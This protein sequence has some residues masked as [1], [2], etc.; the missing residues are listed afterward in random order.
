MLIPLRAAGTHNPTKRPI[1]GVFMFTHK[2]ARRKRCVAHM[3][4][5]RFA[6]TDIVARR[7]CPKCASEKALACAPIVLASCE[8]MTSELL[9]CLDILEMVEAFVASPEKPVWS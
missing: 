1:K 5:T 9:S 8:P 7:L 2:P 3:R 4:M 6:S